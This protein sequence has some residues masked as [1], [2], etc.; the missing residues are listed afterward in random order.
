MSL[1]H[2]RSLLCAIIAHALLLWHIYQQIEK[3]THHLAKCEGHNPVVSMGSNF[4]CMT[5][6]GPHLLP[7]PL[8]WEANYIL[9]GF[10]LL[11]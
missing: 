4:V 8:H 7:A 2:E 1:L 11:A 10:H 5:F 3:I 9:N 6:K